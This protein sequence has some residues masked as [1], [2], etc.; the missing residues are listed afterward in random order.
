MI[1]K[2]M[3]K[4]LGV[5]IW[6][7]G[8]PQYMLPSMNPCLELVEICAEKLDKGTRLISGDKLN[9]TIND[10]AIKDMLC[11]LKHGS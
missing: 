6:Y 9:I 7:C 2:R 3:T 1:T 11:S 4:G 8:L 5:M 10:A